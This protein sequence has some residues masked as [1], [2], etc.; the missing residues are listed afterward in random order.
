MTSIRL[1][2]DLDSRLTRL[3]TLTGRTKSFYIRR[4][5]EDHI[6]ELEDRFIA[7]HRLENPAERMTSRDM[8]RDLGLD[9]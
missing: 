8:R 9:D 3:A 4:L 5:I 7:E 1:D 2:K 6:D